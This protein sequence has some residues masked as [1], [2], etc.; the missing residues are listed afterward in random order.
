MSR[1]VLEIHKILHMTFCKTI[2]QNFHKNCH[3]IYVQ[4]LKHFQHEMDHFISLPE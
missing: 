1:F 2:L 4:N 3:K